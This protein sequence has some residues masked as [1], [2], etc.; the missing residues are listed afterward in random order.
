[1]GVGKA[2]EKEAC[3]RCLWCEVLDLHEEYLS[4]EG[5]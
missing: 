5:Y 2:S 1:L 3:E 4:S